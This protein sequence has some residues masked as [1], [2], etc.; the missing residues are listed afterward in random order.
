MTRR[1]SPTVIALTCVIAVLL[2][3][4]ALQRRSLNQSR[5]G[6]NHARDAGFLSAQSAD[7]RAGQVQPGHAFGTNMSRDLAAE[8]RTF[9]Q[10]LEKLQRENERLRNEYS[11]LATTNSTLAESLEAW[12]AQSVNTRSYAREL[13]KYI[14]ELLGDVAPDVLEL[15]RQN[16]MI[17]PTDEVIMGGEEARRLIKSLNAFPGGMP[18]LPLPEGDEVGFNA[19]ALERMGFTNYQQLAIDGFTNISVRRGHQN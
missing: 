8:L 6:L 16:A 18:E 13:A 9:Q 2:V 12:I 14:D 19:V 1:I 17:Q 11:R 5:P 7:P 15:V 4:L 10:Q 3:L